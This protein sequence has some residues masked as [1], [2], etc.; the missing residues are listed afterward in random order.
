MTVTACGDPSAPPTWHTSHQTPLMRIGGEVTRRAIT[1]P[2]LI[3]TGCRG[4]W[5]TIDIIIIA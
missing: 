3:N 2:D 1:G 5:F 4:Q